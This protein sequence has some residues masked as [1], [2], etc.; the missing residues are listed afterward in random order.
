MTDWSLVL[1]PVSM[2]HMSARAPMVR[3]LPVPAGQ[4]RMSTGR[5]LVRIPY[6]AAAW[7]GRRPSA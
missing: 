1:P 3:G 2:S 4:T 5:P 7:S 6:T